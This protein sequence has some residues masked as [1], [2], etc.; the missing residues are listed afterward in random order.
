MTTLQI[1]HAL[2]YIVCE[3]FYNYYAILDMGSSKNAKKWHSWQAAAFCVFV[4]ALVGLP[5]PL[6]ET[7]NCF[8][9]YFLLAWLRW[10][11]FDAGLNLLRGYG[12]FYIG[13]TSSIDILLRKLHTKLAPWMPL[14]WFVCFV[15]ILVLALLI[16]CGKLLGA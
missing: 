11:L 14:G 10:L 9:A 7:A 5:W 16:A 6:T 2:A 3:V 1:L 12:P 8:F 4:L 13:T 15:K